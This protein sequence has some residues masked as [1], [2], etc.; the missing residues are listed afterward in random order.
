MEEHKRKNGKRIAGGSPQRRSYWQ[1]HKDWVAGLNRGQKLRYRLFQALTA[2]SAVIVLAS[3]ALGFW[4]KMPELPAGIIVDSSGGSDQSGVELEGGDL[5]DIA[6]SGR[7][8]GVYT[9]LVAGKDVASGGTDTILLLSYDT[10]EKTIHGLNLPRDTMIN[11]KAASKRINSVYSRNRGSKEM[12]EAARVEQ[13]MNAL[14]KEVGNLTGIIPDFYVLVEWKAIGELVDAIG[15][16]EFK[17][18]F[19]MNYDDPYQDLHIHQKAGLRKLSGQDAMEVIRWRKNNTGSSGGDVARLAIQQDF[20]KAVVKTCLQPSIF[21]KVPELARIFTENVA[22]NLTVG[23]ILAFAKTAN[24]MDPEKDVS[25][26]TAPLADSFMYKRAALITLDGEGILEIV[27]EGMNPYQRDIRLSDL[28]LIYRKSNGGFGVTN[29]AL[30][31]PSMAQPAV[32]TRPTGDESEEPEVPITEDPDVSIDSE[33]PGNP[34]DP[35]DPNAPVDSEAPGQ[36]ETPEDP[37]ISEDPEQSPAPEGDRPGTGEETQPPV[38]GDEPN[39]SDSSIQQPGNSQPESG[40]AVEQ[41]GE[42]LDPETVLPP[43]SAETETNLSQDAA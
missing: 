40:N 33:D 15:G 6:Q 8:E 22:T 28:K 14:K 17:V 11:T 12:G 39:D 10:T 2:V 35:D 9:F 18:P 5:P 25:F 24:G 38:T 30:A 37:D 43:P 19:D 34:T 41:A 13:G 31:D 1:Q 20:L 42:L 4:V 23:N 7:K 16:V 36:S 3:L 26:E 32:S 29:G 27:N 21:L